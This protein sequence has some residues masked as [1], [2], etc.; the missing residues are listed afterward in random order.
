MGLLAQ[1]LRISAC[2]VPQ[3]QACPGDWLF[4]FFTPETEEPQLDW[5]GLA[6]DGRSSACMLNAFAR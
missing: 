4:L 6:D 2:T 3:A 5:W 1:K